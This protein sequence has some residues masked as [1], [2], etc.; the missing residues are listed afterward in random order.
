MS[1]A[2][3]SLQQILEAPTT[4]AWH[5]ELERVIAGERDGT[6]LRLGDAGE[7]VAAQV[8]WSQDR[9]KAAATLADALDRVLGA[10]DPRR[11]E[12]PFRTWRR[13]DIIRHL[14][15]PTGF[16]RV[17]ELFDNDAL[18][19]LSIPEL[20]GVDLRMNAL[21]TLQV[22]HRAPP[23]ERSPAFEAA[24]RILREHV[25]RDGYGAAAL[26]P[27]IALGELDPATDAAWLFEDDGRLTAILSWCAS[28]AGREDAATWLA[29]LH[30]A[31]LGVAAEAALNIGRPGR[32]A[33]FQRFADFLERAGG[34]LHL[35]RSGP[36]VMVGGH[37]QLIEVHEHRQVYYLH[38]IDSLSTAQAF[39]QLWR[40]K[41]RA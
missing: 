18:L 14:R 33:A 8:T 31:C 41:A 39:D 30:G 6:V 15:P 17:V 5:E 37:G 1:E 34:S 24:V 13:L 26:R 11:K 4:L 21:H 25:D 3:T 27:L 38:F 32:D 22:Y 23:L 10:W 19:D 20:P 35:E 9:P 16:H 29:A 7:Y 28:R 2:R 40:V 12:D 36:R